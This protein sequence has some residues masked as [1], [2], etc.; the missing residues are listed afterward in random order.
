MEESSYSPYVKTILSRKI[1]LH[2]TQLS[3][4]SLHLEQSLRNMVANKC[5]ED[6]YICPNDIDIIQHSVGIIQEEYMT[7]QVIFSCFVCHPMEGAIFVAK[8]KSITLA[9]IH[10]EIMDTYGNIPITVFVARDHHRPLQ[11]FEHI[12]EHQSI[13]VKLLG[14]RFEK[15]DPCIYAIAT[16]QTDMEVQT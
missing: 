12:Q 2:V 1:Q 6:G 10:A 13:Y 15:N 9:G 8:V 7:F 4:L 16:M 11:I 3:M 5:T 14:I